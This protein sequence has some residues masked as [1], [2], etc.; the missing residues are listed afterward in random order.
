MMLFFI[1]MLAKI[2]VHWGPYFFSSLVLMI[3]GGKEISHRVLIL[4]FSFVTLSLVESF[5]LMDRYN[6]IFKF[7]NGLYFL[8]GFV[9]L[10]LFFQIKEKWRV[11]ST[12]VLSG[13]FL[14]CFSFTFA[15]RYKSSYTK[16]TGNHTDPAKYLLQK[17]FG[18]YEL[19]QW[20]RVKVKGL[21]TIVEAYGKSFD[22]ESQRISSNVA[23]PSYMGW[24][25]HVR[26]RGHKEY[27]IRH[28]KMLTKEIYNSTDAAD[29]HKKLVTARI[30]FVVV[31]GLEHERYKKEGLEKF[32]NN[33]D[34]FSLVYSKN[35]MSLYGVRATG[36]MSYLRMEKETE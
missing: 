23:L 12:Y 18:D 14:L 5:S 1:L 4:I 22:Y 17:R 25:N 27:K 21:P 8:F 29:I 34:Y 35:G 26:L 30:R 28:R 6:T 13:V 16:K 9:L 19:V 15:S 20:M 32:Q 7:F 33:P 2:D 3:L 24:E 11:Y 10:T 31:G 36:Y